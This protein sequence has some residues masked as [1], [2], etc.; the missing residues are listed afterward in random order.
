MSAKVTIVIPTWN[1]K[2]L[3]RECLVSIEAQT[4]KEYAVVVVDDASTDGTVDDV[5]S[6]FPRTRIVARSM[7]GGFCAAVND[8]VREAD[9]EY[10]LLLNNDM[11]L[12]MR[13]VEHLIARAES[14]DAAMFAPLVVFRAEPTIVYG[15]GDLQRTDGRPESRGFRQPLG[16]RAYGEDVFGVSAGAALYRRVVFETVG[17]LDERFVAYF[18]DSDLNFRARLAGFRA[19]FVGDAKAKHVGSASLTGRTWWRTRQCYRNH[20]LLLIKNM[21]GALLLRYLPSIIQERWRGV[22]RV[23]SAARTE[24]GLARALGVLLGVWLEVA[25]L[26][27]HAL[28]ARRRIQRSRKISVAEL[29]AILTKP[30]RLL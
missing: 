8:G 21:P 17:L 5:K 30:E 11:T 25:L 2:E 19:C 4:F 22:G 23:V 7:N 13:C 14:S 6:L 9:G 20:A 24:F 29:D 1:R 3:L 27:P 16:E 10:V 28:I 12:D 15:A 18:E 26:V